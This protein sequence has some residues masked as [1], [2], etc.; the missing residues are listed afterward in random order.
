MSPSLTTVPPLL[1]QAG[2]IVDCTE[3]TYNELEGSDLGTACK[4]CPEFSTSPVSSTSVNDCVCQDGFIQTILPDGSAKCEC[5]AGKEIM[6]GVRC[7]ACQPGTYK[8][9]SGNSK[10]FECY[11]S[12]LPLAA[13]E[14]TTTRQLGSKLPTDCVCKVTHMNRTQAHALLPP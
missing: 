2:L 6:N 12:P 8:P 4:S 11:L 1:P 10:C 9:E 13:K 7:D 3:G 5:D 14:F